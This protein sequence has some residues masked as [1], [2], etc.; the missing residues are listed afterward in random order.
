MLFYCFFVTAQEEDRRRGGGGGG[1]GG[2]GGA[3]ILSRSQCLEGNNRLQS[4][5][6]KIWWKIEATALTV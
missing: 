2:G 1:L 3:D 6:H 5:C 4:L